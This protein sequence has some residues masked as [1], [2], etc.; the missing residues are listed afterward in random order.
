[1]LVRKTILAGLRLNHV[2]LWSSERERWKWRKRCEG[3]EEGSSFYRRGGQLARGTP[4]MP[5]PLPHSCGWTL[6][7]P[8]KGLFNK[9]IFIYFNI[10]LIHELTNINT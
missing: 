9:T 1:M 2:E 10:F 8:S 4:A 7:S 5:L 6:H 3:R